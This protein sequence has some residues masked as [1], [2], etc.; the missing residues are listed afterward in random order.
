MKHAH[1]PFCMQCV[2]ADILALLL[3]Q[4]FG[5]TSTDRLASTH[6]NAL[7]VKQAR[8][9]AFGDACKGH[10]LARL[11]VPCVPAATEPSQSQAAGILQ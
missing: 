3:N 4:A 11:E 7:E 2:S 5:H 9:V 8:R 10:A 6:H 1:M